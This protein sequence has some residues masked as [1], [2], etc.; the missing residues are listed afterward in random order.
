M[1]I[2]ILGTAGAAADLALRLAD[3]QGTAPISVGARL[4]GSDGKAAPDLEQELERQQPGPGFVLRDG[5]A[6]PE[7]A[8]ALD[9]LLDA[10]DAPLDL[11]MVIDTGRETPA[12]RATDPL[13]DYYR[14]RGLLR[15]I[16]GEG[17]AG[18]LL[19]A[20]GRI[21]DD[22]IRAR[23]PEQEDPFAATLQAIAEETPP[24]AA[25]DATP[26]TAPGEESAAVTKPATGAESTRDGP[27]WKRAAVQK[28]RLRRQPGGGKGGRKPRR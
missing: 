1:R 27:G 20:A 18:D 25:R 22:L 12:G 17:E 11:V 13:W 4:S 16:R 2:M 26:A 6:T 9:S 10:L 24:P 5:P 15:R 23:R 19:A 28:G 8:A 21:V 7:Q 14:E 3:N